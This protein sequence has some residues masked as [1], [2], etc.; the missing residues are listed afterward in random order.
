MA[1]VLQRTK[2]TVLAP[3]GLSHLL[4]ASPNLMSHLDEFPQGLSRFGVKL[5]WVA[6]RGVVMD[7]EK[8]EA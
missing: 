4:A 7:G 5:P 8:R 2:N 6:A 3:D 1:V